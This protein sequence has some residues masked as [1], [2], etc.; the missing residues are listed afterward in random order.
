MTEKIAG[1]TERR[2]RVSSAMFTEI[3]AY[4]IQPAR[5][6]RFEA[7]KN[8]LIDEAKTIPGLIS[9]TTAASVEDETLFVDTMVWRSAEAA[10]QG[11]VTFEQ[12]PT[13]PEFLGMMAGPPEFG[14][15]FRQVAPQ[16]EVASAASVRKR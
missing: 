6:D 9:S 14:G 7:I 10:K 16:A 5:L 8:T 1:H 3:I 4:R 15:R 13:T 2:D 11:R 12:L